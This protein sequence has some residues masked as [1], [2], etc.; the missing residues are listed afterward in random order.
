[1]SD[2][3]NACGQDIPEGSTHDETSLARHLDWLYGENGCYGNKGPCTC[4]HAWKSLG[5]L[6]R[7][8]MGK[9]WVR[10]NTDPDC[11]NHGR[12]SR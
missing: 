5:R 10:T 9:G 1:M 12:V 3:C 2:T 8:N 6:E 7:V 11:P 4:D